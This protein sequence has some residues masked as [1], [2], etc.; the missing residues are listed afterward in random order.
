MVEYVSIGEEGRLEWETAVQ[1]KFNT[2]LRMRLVKE[3]HLTTITC[4]IYFLIWC[5]IILGIESDGKN[6]EQG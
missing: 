1:D 5:Y 2:E 6:R 3:Y 4:F